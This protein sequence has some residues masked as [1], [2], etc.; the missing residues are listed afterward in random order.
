MADM[1]GSL[2]IPYYNYIVHILETHKELKKTSIG[3]FRHMAW[4]ASGVAVGGLVAGP[5]GALLGGIA[6]SVYGYL[7][8]D[9][10]QSLVTVVRALS[11]SEREELVR[12]VQELV[13]SK[14]VEALSTFIGGGPTE[15]EN[16]INLIREF[17]S[18]VNA[19][20]SAHSERAR[21]TP[22][23]PPPTQGSHYRGPSEE[24][25]HRRPTHQFSGQAQN[26]GKLYP[27]LKKM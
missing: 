18:G 12:R 6:G 24:D 17:I 3:I 10:Y 8:S 21:P 13:G 4:A 7:R 5:P 1:A 19:D 20:R 23:A 16:F 22:S 26:Y 11:D 9:D 2:F 27:D 14:T 25:H 15:R